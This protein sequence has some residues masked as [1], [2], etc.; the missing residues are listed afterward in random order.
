MR[1]FLVAAL[2][3]AGAAISRAGESYPGAPASVVA[4]FVE[5]DGEG[6]AL[7]GATVPDVLKYTTWEDAPG[8]DTFT[9][10]TSYDIGEVGY[11]GGKAFVNITYHIV[12]TISGMK[13][14]PRKAS[15]KT[16]TFEVVKQGGKWKIT[17][18][19]NEP[20]LTIAS[21]EKV[22]EGLGA[23]DDREGRA[24]LKTLSALE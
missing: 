10:M 16:V 3:V 24:S 23:K 6:L 17:D 9:V 4:A 21:A 14:T 11:D 22:L 12:G 1:A 18:P 5:A 8:Y 19:Q 15:D 20:H 7:D 13:F 2:L